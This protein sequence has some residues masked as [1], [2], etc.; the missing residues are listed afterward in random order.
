MAIKHILSSIKDSKDKTREMINLFTKHTM[1]S[2]WISSNLKE[3][4][5]S[6]P[7]SY[8]A[9]R[10]QKVILSNKNLT[11]LLALLMKEYGDIIGI[12]IEHIT[13]KPISLL[14]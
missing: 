8:I 13:D 4:R 6:Y 14:L 9:I 12:T 1:D 3:L 2:K 11:E 5:I 7:N 10:D